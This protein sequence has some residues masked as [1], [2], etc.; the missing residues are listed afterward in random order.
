[1][2]DK[3]SGIAVVG[4]S[5][6]AKAMA[7]ELARNGAS[8]IV[9]GEACT[10]SPIKVSVEENGVRDRY[11]FPCSTEWEGLREVDCVVTAL[12]GEDL[13]AVAEPLAD[14]MR[15]DQMLVMFPGYFMADS[16]A[17]VFLRSGKGGIPICEITS[18]PVV[19]DTASDGAILI[20]KRKNSLKFAS[21]EGYRK[22]EAV[23]FMKRFLPMLALASDTT[24][25]S[26]EN[27]NSVLHPLPILLNLVAGDKCAHSFRHF[28]DGVDENVSI[29]M[30]LM[31]E[32]RCAVGRSLGLRLEPVLDQ[33]KSYYGSN[34]AGSIYEYIQS[35]DCPYGEIHGF[36]L[37]SRYIT[38]DVPNLVAKTCALARSKKVPTPVFDSCL[39]LAGP[40]LNRK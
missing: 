6:F 40:F 21:R 19:C 32:E 36:G 5:M 28:F 17:E 7:A 39:T 37:G 16:M 11:S 33:L 20:H 14:H 22:E 10:A 26:L 9:F 35:P 18:A 34:D 8:V 30:H 3:K 1:M 31:D 13:L 29:L 24:E 4:D 15:A 27:I 25:T 38:L 2:S 12:I 23:A